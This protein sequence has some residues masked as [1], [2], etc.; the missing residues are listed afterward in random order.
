MDYCYA[1]EHISDTDKMPVDNY[2]GYLVF[3]LNSSGNNAIQICEK[4]ISG[5]KYAV[6]VGKDYIYLFLLIWSRSYVFRT[7]A[8]KV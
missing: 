6:L 7:L 3:Y 1:A 8:C 4:L 5:I 2:L